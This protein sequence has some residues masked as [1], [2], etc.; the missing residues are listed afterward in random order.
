MRICDQLLRLPPS[1]ARWA[2]HLSDAAGQLE[3]DLTA[4]WLVDIELQ[5]L[6]TLVARV[7][8]LE[9][10]NADGPS[11]LVASLSMVAELLKG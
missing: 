4:W 5:A 7:R 1:Q 3:A 9:L 11:S 2:N 8:V 10:G 6:Q